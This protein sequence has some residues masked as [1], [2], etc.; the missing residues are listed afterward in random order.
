[1][2]FAARGT[3]D[4]ARL[5]NWGRGEKEKLGENGR[6]RPL[7]LALGR[8]S[9]LL[10]GGGVKGG[11]LELGGRALV[12]HG[13]GLESEVP[14]SEGLDVCKMGGCV[15]DV[16]VGSG[17]AGCGCDIAF[18]VVVALRFLVGWPL[19][20]C[21]CCDGSDC[22]GKPCTLPITPLVMYMLLRCSMLKVARL[23]IN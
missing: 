15:A 23:P 7:P 20:Y 1:M 5:A 12:S 8:V 16:G 9:E 6:A 13:L 4:G 10:C 21:G 2:R 17:G 14:A 19:A 3:G 22:F 11:R 18:E